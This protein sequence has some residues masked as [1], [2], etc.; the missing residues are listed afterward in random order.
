MKKYFKISSIVL[1][2]VCFSILLYGSDCFAKSWR[3]PTIIRKKIVDPQSINKTSGTDAGSKSNSK[4]TTFKP[5]SDISFIETKVVPVYDPKGKIDP[6]E[7][8]FEET[9]KTKTASAT[10]ADTDHKPTTDIEKVDLS[11]LR[12]TGIILAASGNK[13]LVQE[14]SGRGHVISKGTRIGTHGGWVSAVLIDKVIVK[15]KM[16]DIRGKFFFQETELKIRNKTKI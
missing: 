7:P 1:S 16:K 4:I 9:P 8:L 5:K 11:Q 15:E 12:L 3:K 2:L 10:Y 6:F 13:A 14:A